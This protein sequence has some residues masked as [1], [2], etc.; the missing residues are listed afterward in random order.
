[1]KT[2]KTKKMRTDFTVTSGIAGTL[3]QKDL[4][5][6]ARNVAAALLLLVLSVAAMAFS[7]KD[8]TK[9][10][11]AATYTTQPVDSCCITTFVSDVQHIVITNTSLLK[12]KVMINNMDINTWVNSLMAYSFKK[13]NI[14][15]FEIADN[16]MDANFTTAEIENRRKAVAYSKMI[17]EEAADA[18]VALTDIYNVTIAAPSYGMA[19]NNEMQQADAGM[20]I[21]INED[22]DLR[23]KTAAYRNGIAGEIGSADVV[24]DQ[25]MAVSNMKNI[26]PASVDYSDRMMDAMINFSSSKN[27]APYFAAEADCELDKLI[28]D[29][30]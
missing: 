2:L 7:E 27:L 6:V 23:Q 29:R 4:V 10:K 15:S 9:T 24:M 8:T 17:A 18:D 21:M 14:H 13:V 11:E 28:N 1:V 26:T 30:S 16:R 12:G 19:I 3:K 22:N 25:M 20:D 5:S